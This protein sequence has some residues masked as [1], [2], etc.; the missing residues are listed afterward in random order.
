[1]PVKMIETGRNEH[2]A[3]DIERRCQPLDE[4]VYEIVIGIRAVVKQRTK[5]CLP[6]LC[7]QNAIRIWFVSEK[8]FK[9]VLADWACLWP[10]RNRKIDKI[11]HQV[12]A[13]DEAHLWIEVGLDYGTQGLGLNKVAGVGDVR[14]GRPVIPPQR[15]WTGESLC[16]KTG[17]AQLV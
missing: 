5:S 6:L 10:W 14:R 8:A 12:S 15:Q 13:H 2:V 4:I 9:V 17:D 1:M 16:P 11:R 3:K 7:L